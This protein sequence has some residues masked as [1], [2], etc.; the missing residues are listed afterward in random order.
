MD[1][2]VKLV[3]DDGISKSVDPVI[4]QSMVG[5][6][7][8]A[9]IATRPDIAHAV[10]TLAKFNSSPNEAHLTAVKQVFRY[11]K[12][13]IRYSSCNNQA[14]IAMSRNSVLHKRPKHIDIKFHFVREKEQDKKIELKYC[15]TQEMTVD[16]FT[17]PLTRGQ[18]ECLRARLGLVQVQ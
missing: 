1:V 13:T 16:N 5:S 8:Y 15:P 9:A 2:N 12:G 3:K 18:F 17:K 7:I 14:T 10:G 11:L 4:Y 6:L